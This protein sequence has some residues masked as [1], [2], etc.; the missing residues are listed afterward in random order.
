MRRAFEVGTGARRT[1]LV[2]LYGGQEPGAEQPV[3]NVRQRLQ[4][5]LCSRE[6]FARRSDHAAAD[7]RMDRRLRRS[8]SSLGAKGAFPKGV[9]S[10]PQ[11]YSRRVR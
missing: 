7:S 5:R 2:V 6:P 1:S 10:A 4:A 3:G 11:T 9:L 8:P